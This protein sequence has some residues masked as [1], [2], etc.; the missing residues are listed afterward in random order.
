MPGWLLGAAVVLGVAHLAGDATDRRA[1]TAVTKPLPVA[2]ALLWAATRPVPV[3]EAYRWL[4]VAGLACSMVGDV[5]LLDEARFVPGLASFLVAHLLYLAAFAAGGG[6]VWTP[7]AVIA[8]ASVALLRVLW[9]HLGDLR[10]PVLAYVAVI[11]AMAWQAVVR[12][13][14]PSTP[15]PSGTLAGVGALVFMTSDATLA[16]DRFARRFA[17][18]HVAVMVT[19][20][21]A[22]LAIAASV[23]R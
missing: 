3:S 15:V 13:L 19:Y 11:G 16:F 18:A 2:L 6:L 21:A 20:Y 10:A 23:A 7:L 5:C 8:A 12:G 1:L 17:G 4:V 14:R 9:P 22:Q